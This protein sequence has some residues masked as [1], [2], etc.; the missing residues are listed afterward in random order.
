MRKIC[1]E[2]EVEKWLIQNGLLSMCL[3]SCLSYRHYLLHLRYFFVGPTFVCQWGYSEA[4]TQTHVSRFIQGPRHCPWLATYFEVKKDS[5]GFTPS[6]SGSGILLF[7]WQN[8]FFVCASSSWD[9]L[10][11]F[12]SRRFLFKRTFT[13][14]P[15]H[16]GRCS[17]SKPTLLSCCQ[18]NSSLKHST[19]QYFLH[20]VYPCAFLHFY[21]FKAYGLSSFFTHGIVA[22]DTETS[23]Y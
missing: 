6:S 15:G 23:T 17:Y 4:W 13:L 20:T 9:N 5:H 18:P 12:P 8:T 11:I 21:S 16:I 1:P 3:A 10:N 19:A 14:P 22:Q 7:I 2:P